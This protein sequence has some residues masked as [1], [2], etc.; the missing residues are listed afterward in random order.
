[1][2]IKDLD[3]VA[4]ARGCHE[5]QTGRHAWVGVGEELAGLVSLMVVGVCHIRIRD[6]CGIKFGS[7]A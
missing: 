3:Q 5:L 1:M 6:Y 4:S 2:G 7:L